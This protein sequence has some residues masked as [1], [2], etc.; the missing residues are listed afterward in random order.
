LDELRQQIM[1]LLEEWAERNESPLPNFA[2]TDDLFEL[3][4]VDSMLMVEIVFAVEEA[5]G[6]VV[7]FLEVDPEIF[8][9][10]AG[11]MKYAESAAGREMPPLGTYR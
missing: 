9:T 10:L 11:I 2:D 3:G 1:H 4:V 6:S 8:Y 5:T 7:D